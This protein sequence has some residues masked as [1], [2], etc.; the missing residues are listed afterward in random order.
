MR[1]QMFSL[2]TNTLNCLVHSSNSEYGKRHNQLVDNVFLNLLVKLREMDLLK[3]EGI[4]GHHLV[5][6]LCHQHYFAAKR[7]RFLIEWDQNSLLQTDICGYVL[8]H[9]AARFLP[10]HGFRSI[11][12]HRIRCYPKKKGVILL[13][14]WNTQPYVTAFMEQIKW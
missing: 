9:Y 13:Y 4:C 3:K 1:C 12:S 11:L 10:F 14:E 7:F 2:P 5:Q 8:L 6:S